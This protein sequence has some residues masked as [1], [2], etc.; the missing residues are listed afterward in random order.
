MTKPINPSPKLSPAYGDAWDDE[1][2]ERLRVCAMS[3]LS[4]KETAD[5]MGRTFMAIKGRSQALGLR[6][7]RD[8]YGGLARPY[9][10]ALPNELRHKLEDSN[11]RMVRALALAISRGDHLPRA[12]Q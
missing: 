2:D 10:I 6:F 1:Q 9:D 4:R 7:T 8:N 3:G 5:L 12:T 11:K